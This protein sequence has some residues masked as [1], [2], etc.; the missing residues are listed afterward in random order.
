MG[1]HTSIISFDDMTAAAFYWNLLPMFPLPLRAT[2]AMPV[3][4][5]GHAGLQAGE[6]SF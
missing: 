6:E 2:A 1:H 3:L 4:V 5:A